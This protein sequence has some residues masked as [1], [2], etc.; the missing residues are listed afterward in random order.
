MQDP[1]HPIVVGSY[2]PPPKH[3]FFN[4]RLFTRPILVIGA[5]VVLV[6]VSAGTVLALH[7]FTHNSSQ[8]IPS[9]HNTEVS[10]TKQVANV[11][12]GQ[13]TAPS[14]TQNAPATDTKSTAQP[15][16]NSTTP[17][18]HSTPPTTTT[19]PPSGGGGTSGGTSSG[20]GTGSTG[21]SSSGGGSTNTS[22]IP[23]G[24]TGNWNLAFSDDFSSSTLNT[25]V[26]SPNWF[27]DGNTQNNT[28][29][30][31][32]NVT[33]S[34]GNANLL[35]NGS[36]GGLLSTN[37]HDYQ[38]GHTG[39]QFTYGFLQARIY[40]PGAAGQIANWPA[41]WT[42]GQNWPNDG[43]IDV[44]EGFSQACY[45]LHFG[46]P[47]NPQAYGSCA[48]GDYSGWHTYGVNWQPGSVTFY[49]DGVA[50]GG[51]TSNVTSSPQYILLENSASQYGAPSS[52]PATMQVDYV[53][54]WQ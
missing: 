17:T 29:M 20:G 27:G 39:F 51:Y 24:L 26:W 33:V 52:L 38:P 49:Y 47:Q 19:P 50:V 35:L 9:K 22:P 37:P 40:L 1:E 21:G 3:R 2:D 25:S 42:D 46:T 31:N 10:T 6:L 16:T 28:V 4:R 45:H 5:S 34:N 41:F 7:V 54:V 48:T 43:E 14:K 53:R 11:A 18:V 15:N 36:S 32:A 12:S 44:M 8:R 30:K 23:L 13:K